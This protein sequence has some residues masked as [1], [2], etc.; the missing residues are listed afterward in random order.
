M[1][2]VTGLLV[3]LAI[4]LGGLIYLPIDGKEPDLALTAFSALLTG[5]I[6][7][8]APSPARAGGGAGG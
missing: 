1:R 8:F 3:L 7:L 6:G 4:A 2:L 5:L